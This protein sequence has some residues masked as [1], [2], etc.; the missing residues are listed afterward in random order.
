MPRRRGGG[1][2]SDLPE[3]I[4]DV[5]IIWLCLIVAVAVVSALIA[6]FKRR[7]RS[8]KNQPTAV[9]ALRARKRLVKALLGDEK[10]ADRLIAY[11]HTLAGKIG[12]GKLEAVERAI[13]KL[14]RDRSRVN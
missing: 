7:A 1:D 2:H 10:A 11:E 5:G 8:T 13:S 12:C 14:Q 9:L 6:F 4:T 3:W